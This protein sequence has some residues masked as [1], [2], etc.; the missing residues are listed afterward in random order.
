[1]FN[2]WGGL[3]FENQDP[4]YGIAIIVGQTALPLPLYGF[5]VEK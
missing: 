5:V 3:F 1:M 4:Y 2:R